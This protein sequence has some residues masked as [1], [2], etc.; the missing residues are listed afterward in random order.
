MTQASSVIDVRWSPSVNLALRKGLH[1]PFLVKCKLD[2]EFWNEC[3][4]LKL[5]N[6]VFVVEFSG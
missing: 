5:G 4:L 6:D 1:F 2:W 3:S